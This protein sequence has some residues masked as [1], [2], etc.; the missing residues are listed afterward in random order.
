MIA[1]MAS[2]VFTGVD[3]LLKSGGDAGALE[4]LADEF[5]R[6][7]EYHLLF[8][9]RLMKKRME[10]GLP[11]I[12]TQD[13]NLLP[14][15]TRS[16]YEQGMVEAAR[17]AG[18][19]YLKDGKIARA[20]PYFR[21]IGDNAPVATAMD[22]AINPD[23]VDG[24]IAIAMQEG[25][26]PLRGLELIVEHQGMCRAITTFGM[27]GIQ[28]DREK[29]IE[30]LTK[31]LHGEIVERMTRAIEGQEGVAP[32]ATNLCELMKGRE[33]LFGEYDY[34]VDTSHLISLLPYCLEVS[35]AETLGLFH[36]LCEYGKK[37]GS[38]FQAKGQP[39][40]ENLYVDYGHYVQAAR[41]LDIEAG[42]AHFRRIADE[43]DPEYVG[44][45]PIQFLIKLL[46]RFDRLD[47]A[48]EVSLSKLG[49]EGA[50]DCPSA[51]QICR[52]AENFTRLQELAKTRGDVLSYAG[53]AIDLRRYTGG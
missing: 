49:G 19:G 22:G 28:K 3:A 13:A 9:A 32:T 53:A 27:F 30:L 20:W 36:E 12:Q 31:K 51:M 18:S 23:D 1:G 37:L 6:T 24:V 8:E 17:E 35:D 48:L 41:G 4:Y 39:P 29:C 34:Y 42:I 25:V 38:N 40:F 16:V 7:G 47:E 50:D 21:A 10:L 5:A 45:G 26:H 33:W 15:E 14:A 44:N 46:V 2:E 11:L 52:L 43:C